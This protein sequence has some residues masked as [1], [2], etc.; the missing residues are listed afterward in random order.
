MKREF[1]RI[2][3]KEKPVSIRESI[4]FFLTNQAKNRI[5]IF[6]PQYLLNNL[7]LI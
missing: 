2:K 3:I 7:K 6:T 1:K 5:F 4:I